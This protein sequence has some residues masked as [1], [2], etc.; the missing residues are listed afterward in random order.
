MCLW[1]I[2][3]RQIYLG[4]S[5]SPLWGRKNTPNHRSEIRCCG[6]IKHKSISAAHNIGLLL[7]SYG[8]KLIEDRHLKKRSRS[9]LRSPIR[10]KITPSLQLGHFITSRVFS[11]SLRCFL[12]GSRC[13]AKMDAFTSAQEPDDFSKEN[14]FT[15]LEWFFCPL[16]RRLDMYSEE[17]RQ[18]C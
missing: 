3:R 13:L 8:I 12:W 10:S 18:P 9:S 7:T 17:W 6:R 5:S 15:C 11:K 1:R 2:S 14:L 16:Q 4:T